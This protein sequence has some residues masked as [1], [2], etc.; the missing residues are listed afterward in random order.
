MTPMHIVVLDEGTAAAAALYDT[1]RERLNGL[2]ASVERVM[3]PDRHVI[4]GPRAHPSGIREYRGT[5]EEAARHVGSADI[6]LVHVA[7]VNG[8]VIRAAPRLRLVGCARSN[9]VNVDVAACHRRGIPVIHTPGRNATAVA[10][11]TLAFILALARRVTELDQAMRSPAAPGLWAAEARDGITGDEVAGATLGIVGFGNIGRLVARRARAFDMQVLAYDPYVDPSAMHRLGAEPASFDDILARSDF[12]TLHA[13][14]PADGRPLLDERAFRR[15]K[16]GARLIN[17]ARA[18]LVDEGALVK[19]LE[20]GHLAGAALDVF[21]SEPIDAGSPLR[22]LPNVI[23]TPHIGGLTHQ[24][25]ARSAHMVVDDVLRWLRGEPLQR[26][27][28]GPASNAGGVHPTGGPRAA[29][30]ASLSD[31]P[32]GGRGA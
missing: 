25:P 8:D 5:P 31:S 12:L 7:P 2:A 15:M 10:E 6:L 29:R 23:L 24:I 30:P 26:A 16:R 21:S 27:F 4:S 17:T 13:A 22:R 32:A 28:P 20:A 11:L 18:R 9:P 14:V 19:A 1:A 3:L